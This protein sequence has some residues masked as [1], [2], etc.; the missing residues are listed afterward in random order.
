LTKSSG[1]LK[2]NIMNRH[3]DLA[4][5]AD[6]IRFWLVLMFV[7][8]VLWI[9][10]AK[11]VVPAIIES[12]Y[13]GES[14]PLLNDMIE[15]RHVNPISYYLQKWDRLAMD[16]LLSGLEMW[17][18]ILVI[19]SPPF[20][21]VFRT[22]LGEA[23][24]V[25]P[26]KGLPNGEIVRHIPELPFPQGRY[27]FNF[28]SM[29]ALVLI[30]VPLTIGAIWAF[31]L[32]D[33]AWVWL[34]LNENSTGILG[35]AWGDR[36]AVATLWSLLATSEHGF[37]HASFVAQ[38]LTWP[39]LGMISAL[40]WI[41]LFPALR[42][43][44]MV[45][46]CV[47]VAPIICK[48]QMITAN[49]ALAHLL[50]VVLSYGAFLLLLRFVTTDD[51]FGRAAL[52][53]SVPM[54]AF[55]ILLTE[56]ALPVVIVMFILFWSCA[57]RAADP[58]TKLR[59]WRAIVFSTLIGGTA[60]GIFFIT[61]NY[62]ARPG[63][64][65]VSPF[66]VLTLG[67]AD[68]TAFTFRVVEGIWWSI[69]GSLVMS[70]GKITLTSSSG[71]LAA[72]YG[73]IIAGLLFY[74]SRNPHHNAKSRSTNAISAR[75]VLPAAMALVA[76][77]VPFVLM[78]RIPWHTGDAI[79]SR[80]ELPLLPITASLI[81]FISLSLAR[82]RFWA[83]PVLLLG[84][85]AGNATFTE[86]WSAIRE[87][88]QMPALGVALQP[89]VSSKDGITV[90]AVALPERSL[91]PRRPYELTVRLAS[92]WPAELR[93]KFWAFR[94]GGGPPN[95]AVFNEAESIFGSRGDC[96]LPQRFKW[97]LRY[98]TREGPLDQL[99][100]VKPQADGSITVEPYCVKGQNGQPVLSQHDSD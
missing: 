18:L 5:R 44:A 25:L 96:K 66:Y 50:S 92:T 24:P 54:L 53:L 84:F 76:G 59:A 60:Y 17:L 64:W 27:A 10:F 7:S 29:L 100:W 77:L 74:G 21:R 48:L 52:A 41:R 51:R 49:I 11:L 80:F 73:A 98:V 33:D 87:R 30:C 91:G 70:M 19:S 58:Q 40:L 56:Y 67:G 81:V 69:V 93:R 6:R 28:F 13:R 78:H 1:G 20:L 88:Q 82:Q 38:A 61:A 79:Q 99:I 57:R 4:A 97:S 72:A 83:V 26:G 86:V 9:A 3:S 95:Y 15:G 37:W 22:F 55:A 36:P 39:L 45:V 34:I 71:I 85:V 43:Y 31:P 47:A 89:H 2:D 32:W 12:A 63:G 90:A 42:R 14:L 94:F 35:T 68:R 65:E 46:A 75:D 16:Y 8:A 23:T 62:D